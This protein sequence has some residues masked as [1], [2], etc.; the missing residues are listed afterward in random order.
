MNSSLVSS[1][2]STLSRATA[3]WSLSSS[4]ALA[5]A[6][7]LGSGSS[8]ASGNELALDG[9]LQ[10][11][12]HRNAGQLD[13][14]ARRELD[15]TIGG[16]HAGVSVLVEGFD[17]LRRPEKALLVH[18]DD[19]GDALGAVGGDRGDGRVGNGVV[20]DEPRQDL[21]VGRKAEGDLMQDSRMEVLVAG[22]EKHRLRK[23][24]ER[25]ARL[26]WRPRGRRRR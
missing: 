19:L 24:C 10:L 8:L 12:E 11:F 6:S 16:R 2:P 15:Q 26:T 22:R 5:N 13:A 18:G 4:S 20:L 14:V 21:V 9:L 25:I 7:S 23:L 17:D 3:S 1:V